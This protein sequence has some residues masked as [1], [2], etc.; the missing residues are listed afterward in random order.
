MSGR[1]QARMIRAYDRTMAGRDQRQYF[2]DSGF[3]NF[4][5]W[6][7]HPRSQGEASEALVDRLIERM[8]DRPGRVLDVA[9]GFGASTARLRCRYRAAQ[10]IAVNI[11]FA[12]LVEAER[13]AP[14]CTFLRMDA[15]RL[16]FPDASFD[17]VLCVEAA[18]HFDTREA[19]LHEAFRVLKPG[20]RLVLTDILVPA[21]LTP[22]APWLQVPR[23]NLEADVDSYA[24]RLSAAGFTVAEIADATEG[25]VG[26]F[27]RHLARW[28]AKQ[29]RAEA[30]SVPRTMVAGVV[31]TLIAG[32][33]RR[34]VKSYLL[35]TAE[36]PP[37]ARHS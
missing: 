21:V 23:A 16:G 15:A 2:D 3:F 14:G 24:G 7:A 11:S 32:Y 1:S 8:G 18:F 36:K 6:A 35:V 31:C 22:I 30:M 20:G 10:I 9:C 5:Y 12:Q 19:F 13:R 17:A 34:A 33:F 25:C 27:C 29:R 4:G 28:P 26:G 37:H